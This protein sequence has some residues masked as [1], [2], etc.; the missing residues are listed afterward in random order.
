METCANIKLLFFLHVLISL[1]I[2][3]YC[4]TWYGFDHEGFITM[5]VDLTYL[6]IYDNEHDDEKVDEYHS[7]E[8]WV[9]DMCEL[10]KPNDTSPNVGKKKD[11]NQ[12]S[13]SS[14]PTEKNI[15]SNGSLGAK[16]HQ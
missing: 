3:Q 11:H 12:P 16:N 2:V 14:I 13:S 4:E 7:E 8:P 1:N 9:V 6:H 10:M 5:F 15:C